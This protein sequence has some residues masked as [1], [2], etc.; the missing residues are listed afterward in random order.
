M[1]NGT[2]TMINKILTMMKRLIFLLL[3]LTAFASYGQ[4][5]TKLA[6]ITNFKRFQI[7]INIS[8]DICFRSIKNIDGGSLGD[9]IIKL[10][11]ETENIKVSYTVGLNACYSIKRFVSLEA[12][13]QY[14]N[15]GNETKFLDLVFDQPDPS[16]PEKAKMIYSYHYIDIPVKVNFTI[17]K[18][19]VRFFTSVGVTTNI[20]I[21]E[22]QIG[23][24]VYSDR[25]ERINTSTNTNYN[26]V[27]IS[28]TISVG[29]DYKINNRMNLRVE[30]TFR[31]GVLK[32]T[33]TP[34]TDYLYSGGL[35]ISYY[36]GL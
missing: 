32:I 13:I 9:M 26:N 1:L 15:K 12:G 27:N 25:T 20:F 8:P 31:Y 30:P 22:T 23:V 11:N 4:E 2:L 10:R 3:T 29:I 24:L 18:K 5:N 17:G 36:F 7:G 35:N 28:P 19:K 6:M 34:V 16:L 21:K 14:S 33:D